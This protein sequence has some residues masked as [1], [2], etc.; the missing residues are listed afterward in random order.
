MPT[1]LR[2]NKVIV[3][4]VKALIQQTQLWMNKWFSDILEIEKYQNFDA[5]SKL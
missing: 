2:V 3:Q 1:S 4:F 5:N